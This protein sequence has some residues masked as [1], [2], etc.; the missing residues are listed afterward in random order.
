MPNKRK[1]YRHIDEQDPMEMD[2][3]RMGR[4]HARLEH[5]QYRCG[6]RPTRPNA[7]W[8]VDDTPADLLVI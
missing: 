4:R 1:V 3:A 7:R 5:H 8:E 6:P 2:A